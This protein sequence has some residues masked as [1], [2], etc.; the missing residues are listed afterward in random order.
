MNSNFNGRF[1]QVTGLFILI[2]LCLHLLTFNN[3]ELHRDELL[4]F[5]QG[6][7]PCFGNAS[8]PP[9][10]GWV[11]FLIKKVFGYSVFGIR[12]LPMVVGALSI[13][14]VAKIVKYMNGGLTALVLACAAFILSPGFLIFGSLYTVNVF[15]QFFWLTIIY[16]FIKMISTGNT[17]LWLWIGAAGGLAFMNKY[18]VVFLYAGFLPALLA[19][20]YRKMLLSKH[21]LWAVAIAL[22][23]VSPNLYWQY[24]HGWPVVHHIQEL[25]KTQMV[26]MTSKNFLADLYTLNSLLTFFWVPGLGVVLLNQAEKKYRYLGLVFLF[27]ISLFLLSGGKAYYVLGLFPM[28]YA[29]SGYVWEKYI[30]RRFKKLSYSVLIFLF[31]FTAISVP[32]SLPLLTFDKLKIYA[33]RTRG[34]AS[35]PFSRWEDGKRYPISQVFSDMTGWKELVALVDIAYRRI[36]EDIRPNATIYAER[37]YG[38][39]GAIHFYGK[40]YGLPEAI[41]FLDSYVLWA[42]DTILRGPMIYINYDIAGL[43]NLF[44]KCTTMG[45]V[46]NP[47]FRERN[48][49]VFLCEN[50]GENLQ[51]VYKQKA[52][53]EKSLYR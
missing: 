45:T 33:E 18:L 14:V 37:N 7:Y 26:N 5:N 3:Y 16:L 43:D 15:E 49:K 39:A 53:E 44:E 10:I 46:T 52:N 24:V 23:I 2:K 27:V 11:S 31:L 4:Y 42:P 50:P 12:L 36:P 29:V 41:T 30:T 1:W 35:Y 19:T 32:L 34:L 40:Q 17:R 47:Y 20:P 51:A 25:N 22:L 38:Y 13:V 8:V 6:D 28:I 21:V 48:L 9:F